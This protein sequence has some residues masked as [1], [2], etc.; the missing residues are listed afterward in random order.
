MYAYVYDYTLFLLSVLFH[1]C[2]IISG[3]L[4]SVH[5]DFSAI[6]HHE[7]Q[8]NMI[9]IMAVVELQVPIVNEISFTLFWLTLK[10]SLNPSFKIA[11]IYVFIQNNFSPKRA[12]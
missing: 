3:V 6:D 1:E 8:E 9:V 7:S 5:N 10:F 2:S 12:T 4:I 11:C